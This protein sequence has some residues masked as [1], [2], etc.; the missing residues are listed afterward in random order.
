MVH[1]VQQDLPEVQ[2]ALL[3]QS[4]QAVLKVMPVPLV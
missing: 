4:V 2:A 1:K 3:D